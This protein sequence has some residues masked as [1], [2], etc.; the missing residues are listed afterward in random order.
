MKCCCICILGI[1]DILLK[2][3]LMVDGG[4]FGEDGGIG[5]GGIIRWGWFILFIFCLLV[6]LDGL[7]RNGVFIYCFRL[8]F[9]GM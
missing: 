4:F 1:W 7:D 2:N 9:Y 8:R 3:N 6:L 5:E